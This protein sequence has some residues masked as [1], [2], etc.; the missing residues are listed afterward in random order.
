MN[1][2]FE[3]LNLGYNNLEKIFVHYTT[4]KV[5]LKKMQILRYSIWGK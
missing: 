3:F 2:E 5:F 1:S 4:E